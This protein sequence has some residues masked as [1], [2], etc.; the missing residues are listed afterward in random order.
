MCYHL[1]VNDKSD[2]SDLHVDTHP[3][4]FIKLNLS[5]H[6]LCVQ[7]HQIHS[8][9]F[10]RQASEIFKWYVVSKTHNHAAFNSAGCWK[11]QSLALKLH[12]TLPLQPWQYQ[13][14]C[15]KQVKHSSHT[16]LIRDAFTELRSQLQCMAGVYAAVP[17]HSMSMVTGILVYALH[18]GF[19]TLD[20]WL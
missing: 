6:R 16:N 9:I 19:P 18:R 7:R 13:Y 8:I 12:M 10:W 17:C 5:H 14:I 2:S 4:F 3:P 20:D 11:I 15:F 1:F